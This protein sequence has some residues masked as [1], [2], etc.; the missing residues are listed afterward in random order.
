MH[1][2]LPDLPDFRALADEGVPGATFG[3]YTRED[4]PE[5][6]A[7]GAV[8][9]FAP[10]PV[11]EQLAARPGLSWLL[12]LTA[13]ID[14]VQGQLPPGV[15][16]FN[17]SRLHD[18]AVAVHAVSLMLSASRRLHAYR[19]AQHART[20]AAPTPVTRLPDSG[21]TTLDGRQVVLWGYGHIGRELDSLLRPFG[22]DVHTI[23]SATP[24]EDRDRLLALADWVILLLPST[25]DTQHIVNADTLALLK[26]GAWLCNVGRGTLIDQ[27]ALLAALDGGHLG[28]AA[29]DV[30]DPEP[31]PADHPLWTRQN[32]ILTPHIASSTGDL[33]HR[34][35]RLT[36]DFILDLDQGHEPPGR[37]DPGRT[38]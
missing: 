5:G 18:R 16:L 32:V 25:P 36:R 2:L 27:D 10:P 20:W 38:Y 3:F 30:T 33:L 8:L 6:P 24:R 9:W 29:M 13:G 14:H 23:R 22:A 19:D 35:A 34:G 11:R 12:T 28:G 1:V 21:L 17:A 26:P 7:D 4:V 37:V 15:A 31:L